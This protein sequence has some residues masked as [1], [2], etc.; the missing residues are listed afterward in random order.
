MLHRKSISHFAATL[1]GPPPPMGPNGRLLHSARPHFVS[2]SVLFILP[3]C[4]SP[5]PH[6]PH[7]LLLPPTSLYQWPFILQLGTLCECGMSVRLSDGTKCIS[8]KPF[9]MC[10]LCVCVCVCE[11]KKKRDATMQRIEQQLA[12]AMTGLCCCCCRSPLHRTRSSFCT[13]SARE[14]VQS[15]CIRLSV[16]KVY[17]FL[18]NITI[19]NK[20][21]TH[22]SLCCLE[23]KSNGMCCLRSS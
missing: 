17:A 15:G 7:R 12:I 18:G 6:R 8:S 19:Q 23:K 14:Y 16:K 2:V 4:F 22:F 5:L 21:S 3:S 9:P 20:H 11:R 1:I 10:C 13:F